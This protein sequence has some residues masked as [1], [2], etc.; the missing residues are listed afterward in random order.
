ML[1]VAAPRAHAAHLRE[2]RQRQH[3]QPPPLGQ[4]QHNGECAADRGQTHGKHGRCHI[5]AAYSDRKD[6][7]VQQGVGMDCHH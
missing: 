6:T 2:P 4:Q 5:M 7:C 3:L 1:H